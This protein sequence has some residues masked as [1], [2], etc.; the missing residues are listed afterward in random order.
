MVLDYPKGGTE[1][2]VDALVR[3]VE[4]KGGKVM[5]AAHVEEVV[6]EGGKACGVRLRGGKVIRASRCE[7]DPNVGVSPAAAKR[8]NIFGSYRSTGG[9]GETFC[10][11]TGRPVATEKHLGGGIFRC[12]ESCWRWRLCT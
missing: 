12:F 6:V 4:G 9:N 11:P 2:L 3:G 7:E 10:G 1:A 8:R 5:L